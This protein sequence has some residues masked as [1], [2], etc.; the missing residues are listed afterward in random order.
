MEWTRF[1]QF[2]EWTPADAAA[3]AALDWGSLAG[4]FTEAFYARVRATPELD[5][6][7]RQT[8]SYERLAQ[9]MRQYVAGLGSPPEGPT[10]L[11]RMRAIAAAHVRVGLTP[12]WYLGAYRLLWAR[13]GQL[14]I[15]DAAGAAERLAAVT[16]R[17]AADMVL[18]VTVYQE[19]LDRRARALATVQDTV[20][21][22]ERQ[23][24]DEAG[25]LAAAATQT[26]AAVGQLADTVATVLG[27]TRAVAREAEGAVGEA[28]TG[29]RAMSALI[30]QLADTERALA[31]LAAAETA[32]A[33]E[34]QAVGQATTL[35]RNIAQQTNLLALN[36]A[37]E[38]ARAGEAGRGF[39]VVADEVKRLSEGSQTATKTID[40]TIGGIARRL[41]TL[42][43]TVEAA[44][45]AQTAHAAAARQAEAALAAVRQALERTLEAFQA[46]A[47]RLSGTDAHVRQLA[48]AAEGLEGQA[49]RVSQ[50]AQDLSR[51]L[52]EAH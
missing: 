30:A 5:A 44:R 41:E 51:A 35:I 50:L 24:E 40:E 8:S 27:E 20:V 34:T 16:K 29:T 31:D 52:E 26:R 28:E 43:A 11:Q 18:T 22:T 12:D 7:V 19:L 46:S 17:L 1:L 3:V 45:Q 47:E 36:A 32:L 15:Q 39:A 38:A 37:I 10:Y 2:L 48:E 21:V 14:A 6:L 33:Q 13:A 42:T 23:L 49:A 25:H 9:T 4:P